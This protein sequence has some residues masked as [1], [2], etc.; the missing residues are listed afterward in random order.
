M[1]EVDVV[2]LAE[3]KKKVNNKWASKTK[4]EAT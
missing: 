3:M 4:T 2:E 1:L